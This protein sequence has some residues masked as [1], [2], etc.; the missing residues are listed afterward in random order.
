MKTQLLFLLTFLP[1]LSFAQAP[2]DIVDI[3]DPNF[4][5]ALLEAPINSDNLGQ[6]IDANNDREIEYWEAAAATELFLLYGDLGNS[7]TTTNDG[8][9]PIED[10]TGIE[11]FI[12]L[13]RLTLTNHALDSLDLSNNL[14]LEYLAVDYNDLVYLNLGNNTHITDLICNNNNLTDLDLSQNISLQEIDLKQNNIDSLNL[15]N[16]LEI[17]YLVCRNNQLI[18][19]NL[20]GINGD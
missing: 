6:H 19:L 1:F 2:T 15:S 5:E 17:N 12:N 14:L 3:P 20:K 7:N 16:N 11:A 13:E 18:Y 10:L 9:G 8:Y 4:K